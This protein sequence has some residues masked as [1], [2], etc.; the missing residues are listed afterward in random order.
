MKHRRKFIAPVS[1]TMA[2]KKTEYREK[3]R[4]FLRATRKA[5]RTCP[6][7]AAIPELRDGRLYG[8]KVSNKIT[9]VHHMF[10]RVGRLLL[11]DRGWL[12][13]SKQGHRFIH[14]NPE[15]SKQHGWVCALGG[16]NS[17]EALERWVASKT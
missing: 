10:G 17:F 3:A 15:I 8:H 14:S 2:L 6:V 7:V 13:V 4:L 9:E 11:D 5:G 12:G 1:K 16:W